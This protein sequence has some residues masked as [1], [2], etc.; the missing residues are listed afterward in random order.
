MNPETKLKVAAEEIKEVLRKHDLAS[1]FS[2]H[3]PGH[4]EF[5]LHLNASHSCA[6][7]YN[8]HEIRFHSKRK[9]YKSQ[10]EQIQKL[11][12]TANML[13]LLCDMTANNFLMLKRLSDNFDK[14]TNAEHR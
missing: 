3:T 8:D 9:D 1:I 2:L 12:N 11:T 5:V 6:Y 4:G 14:L 7:I 13:K 10:E